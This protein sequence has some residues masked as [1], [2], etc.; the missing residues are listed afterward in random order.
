MNARLLDPVTAIARSFEPAVVLHE[1]LAVAGALAAAAVGV[2][3]VLVE[4][5]LFDART[6]VRETLARMGATIPAHAGVITSAPPSVL[7][8]RNPADRPM[9]AIAYGGTAPLPELPSTGLPLIAV[10][11]STVAGPGRDRLMDRVVAAAAAVDADILLVRPPR[12][13]AA[14]P[15]VHTTGWAPIPELLEHCAAVVHHGGAGT[16]LAA[17]AAGVPQLVVNGAG[18]RRH[19]AGLI[20]G[21]GAGIA[22]DEAQITASA[23]TRLIADDALAAAVR[24]VRGEMAAMPAPA[25]LVPWLVAL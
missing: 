11:R 8:G 9:R 18:D 2:P 25:T 7:P 20:A 4:N 5:T 10:S 1:P 3:A 13:F 14:P 19:N 15:N 21:R 17:L 12:E 22:L 6:L 24:E 23:L 16:T